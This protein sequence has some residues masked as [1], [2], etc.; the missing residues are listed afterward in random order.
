M[1]VRLLELDRHC[2]PCLQGAP[3]CQ[4][5]FWEAQTPFRNHPLAAKLLLALWLPQERRNFP[6]FN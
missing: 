5:F 6:W 2:W 1:N 4:P 3:V